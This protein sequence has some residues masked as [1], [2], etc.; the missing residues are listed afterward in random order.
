MTVDFRIGFSHEVLQYFAHFRYTGRYNESCNK[1][2][3]N[4]CEA[5][6]N[7]IEASIKEQNILPV[8]VE[9][10]REAA[11]GSQTMHVWLDI[12]TIGGK[13]ICEVL[14]DPT[15][16]QNTWGGPRKIKMAYK[17][18]DC[19]CEYVKNFRKTA[20]RNGAWPKD[21]KFIELR[22]KMPSWAG[23]GLTEDEKKGD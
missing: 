18:A 7:T 9:H 6:N 20:V 16:E 19:L 2:A 22:R 10:A 11:K 12:S 4:L 14:F 23:Y 15:N 1:L 17:F 8:S 21:W 3:L 5:M 13:I